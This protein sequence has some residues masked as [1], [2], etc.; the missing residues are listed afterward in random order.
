MRKQLTANKKKEMKKILKDKKS[1]LSDLDKLMFLQNESGLILREKLRQE[2]IK[3]E[4]E[5]GI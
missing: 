3:M 2:I 5:L 1:H 4:K